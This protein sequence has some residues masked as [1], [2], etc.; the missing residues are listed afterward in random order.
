MTAS[1]YGHVAV[2]RVL[3]E[4]HAD[5][6]SQDKVWY[7]GQPVHRLCDDSVLFFAQEGWTALHMASYEGFVDVI[8]VLIEAN[9]DLNQRMKVI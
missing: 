2:V 8:R 5:I 3:I 9:A 1:F 6:H 4:A 7:T